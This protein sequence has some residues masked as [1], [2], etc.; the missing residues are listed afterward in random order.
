M[1]RLNQKSLQSQSP[2]F[3]RV[4]SGLL[5]R[6][7]SHAGLLWWGK[8][9]EQGPQCDCCD[10]HAAMTV[11]PVFN[12]GDIALWSNMGWDLICFPVWFTGSHEEPDV[13][14]KHMC[15]VSVCLCRGLVLHGKQGAVLLTWV[16]LPWMGS[17][18]RIHSQHK[19]RIYHQGKRIFC[20]TH[21]PRE[22]MAGLAANHPLDKNQKSCCNGINPWCWTDFQHDVRKC[23][24]L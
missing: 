21:F 8:S 3:S 14:G 2:T 5:L 16:A 24:I 1:W 23:K 15:G 20:F 22:Q 17:M 13:G 10:V 7:K 9:E 12:L 4:S 11:G 6:K 18:P 19:A